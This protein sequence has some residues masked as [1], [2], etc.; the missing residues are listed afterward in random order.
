MNKGK[1]I[2]NASNCHHGGGKTLI[3]GFLKGVSNHIQ[4]LLYVDDRLEINFPI[5]K[6]IKIIRTNRYSRFF[7]GLK[8]KNLAKKN[9]KIIYFG[10]LP[11]YINFSCDNVLLQLSSRFYVD[12]ISMKGFKLKDIVK[13]YLEKLYFKLFIKNVSQVIVQTSTMYNKLIES[14]FKKRISIWAFDD[15]GNQAYKKNEKIEKEKNTFI[16]V[17]SLLPYKNHKRLLKTWKQLKS[18]GICPKLYLT[19]DGNSVL[20]KW[21]KN[22]VSKN[23]LNVIFLDNVSREELLLIYHKVE[24]LIYPSL[25]E[26][27]GLPLIEAKKYKMKIIASDLDYCWDFIEPDYFFNPY[28]LNSIARSVKRFLKKKKDLDIIYDPKEFFNKILDI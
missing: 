22:F 18:E 27:Y 25:F 12:S 11:P 16:Y 24:A 3:H 2:V 20:K 13:I 14:G 5:N 7:V 19:I 23:Q 15:L 10:N 8:I 1:L 17:A 9:D 6:S 21:I 26:A 28:D 4:T